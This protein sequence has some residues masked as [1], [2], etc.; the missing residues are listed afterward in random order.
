[1][2]LRGGE[3]TKRRPDA[4]DWNLEV[5]AGRLWVHS[6]GRAGGRRQ[7]PLGVGGRESG[8]REV[9]AD[10]STSKESGTKEGN[11]LK[12]KYKKTGMGRSFELGLPTSVVQ[13]KRKKLKKTSTIKK[14]S[15]EFNQGGSEK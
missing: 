5:K 12:E 8:G 14:N 4:M 13:K 1:M 2:R 9:G 3:P 7:K 15:E 11:A 6:T 10:P